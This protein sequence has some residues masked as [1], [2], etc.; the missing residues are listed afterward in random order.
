MKN[1]CFLLFAGIVFLQTGCAMIKKL[2]CNEGVATRNAES[3]VKNGSTDQPGIRGGESCDGEYGRSQFESDYRRAYADTVKKTRIA[4]NAV[5]AEAAEGDAGAT[6]KPQFKQFKSCKK[7][8][9]TNL[10]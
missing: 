7:W 6:V 5:K 10:S 4:E 9:L 1:L 8:P 2:T 3:D